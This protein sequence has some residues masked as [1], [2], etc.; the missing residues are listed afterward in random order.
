MWSM[1][2]DG[3]VS[4][5]NKGGGL[6]VRSRDRESIERFCD[7]ARVKRSRIVEDGGT[8]YQYRV[9]RVAK[10]DVKRYLCATVDAVTYTN[11]KDRAKVSRGAAYAKA[12]SDVWLAMWSMEDEAAKK[13]FYSRPWRRT[14]VRRTS[15]T[16]A[17]PEPH[18]DT[19]TISELLEM[20]PTERD[21]MIGEL[22]GLAC[23][24]DVDA[25]SVLDECRELGLDEPYDDQP[26]HRMT[27]AEFK[28]WERNGQ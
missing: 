20:T 11:F 6:Q 25:E 21:E 17:R 27:D 28:E 24:G 12:L 10:K 5:V 13:R 2:E 9:R 8:D 19:V 18:V 1:T 15:S 16:W 7:L 23:A 3:F 14:P 22:Y 4:I 26:L